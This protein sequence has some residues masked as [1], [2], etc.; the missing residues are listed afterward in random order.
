MN[1]EDLKYSW[2]SQQVTSPGNSSELK[3]KLETDW[4][5]YQR[6]VLRSNILLSIC[7][8]LT[9]AGIACF[10]FYYRDKFGIAFQLSIVFLY[11]L[12]SV[13]M[14]VTWKSYAFR[15]DHRTATS[16][17]YID[18]QLQKLRWQR[19]IL[20]TYSQIYAVLL[21]LD[22]MCYTWEITK[23]GTAT[24]RFTA[25]IIFTLYIAG[26]NVWHKLTKRKK[27]LEAIDTIVAEL[28]ELKQGFAK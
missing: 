13:Y 21:W 3:L 27:A 15:R 18:Y 25:M 11:V 14:A 19:Q 16:T 6:K 26:V 2:K 24:F 9:F 17:D 4:N 1:F 20:T 8:A 22:L 23:H 10:Y 12:M 7:F 28:D 5:K